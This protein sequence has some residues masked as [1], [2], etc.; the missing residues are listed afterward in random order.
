M[1]R[2]GLNYRKENG[3]QQTN[4]QDKRAETHVKENEP[5]DTAPYATHDIF[6]IFSA[7]DGKVQVSG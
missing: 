1:I 4:N 5:P 2:A 3:T 7:A 6:L